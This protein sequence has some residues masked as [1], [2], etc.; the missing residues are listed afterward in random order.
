MIK[1]LS[2]FLTPTEQFA[3]DEIKHR[4]GALFSVEQ[5][6]LFGS[7][8]RGE[9]KEFSDVDVLVITDDALS[10]SDKRKISDH[11]F[12]VNIKYNTQFS[13]ISFSSADFHSDMWSRLPF[14]KSVASEGI[15]V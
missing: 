10:G 13:V 5:F 15:L 6:I 7:K 1:R 3:L 8:A 4:I 2:S 12:E 11:V 14:F 9:A